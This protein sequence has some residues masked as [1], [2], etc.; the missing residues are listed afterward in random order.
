M[1]GDVR[2]RPGDLIVADADGVVVVPSLKIKEVL[3]KALAT[4][5]IEI[6]ILEAALSGMPLNEARKKFKYHTLQRAETSTLAA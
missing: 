2:V 4:R 3:S 5:E 6:Q 1:L